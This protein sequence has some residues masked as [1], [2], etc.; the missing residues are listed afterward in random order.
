MD[1]KE[2]KPLMEKTEL[3]SLNPTEVVLQQVSYRGH[4]QAALVKYGT[5]LEVSVETGDPIRALYAY[6]DGGLKERDLR[7]KAFRWRKFNGPGLF[8]KDRFN[9]GSAKAVTITEGEEDAMAVY[10]MTGMKY[11]VVSVQSSGSA[12]KDVVADKDWVNSFE[13]I[14]IDFDNDVHGDKAAAAVASLF[15]YNKVRIVKKTKWKDANDFLQNNAIAEYQKIWFNAKPLETDNLVSSFSDLA[16]ILHAPDK[17]AIAHFPFKELEKATLGIRTG[18]T[19]LFKALEGI[20][21]TELLGAIEYYVAKTTDVPIGIIHLEEP[22][23]RSLYRFVNYEIQ[24]PVHLEGISE[25][26]TEEEK[27]NI[28]KEIAKTDNRISFYKKGKNDVN[29]DDF[30]N[31]VRFMVSSAGCKIV[32]FDH[33][34]RLATTFRLDDERKELDYISTKLSEMAEELNFALLM[35]THVNDD[36]QTRGSRNI[37]K[38][39]W[40]VIHLTRDPKAEDPQARNTTELLIEK[41]RHASTT[42]PAGAIHFNPN[43]FTLS[44]GNPINLPPTGNSPSMPF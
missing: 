21:K 44:D 43:T 1:E 35:I 19:Y 5:K 8:G 12:V 23:K 38:E 18:E 25:D 2:G 32:F 9:A 17:K 24:Q 40:T 33:I 20:G 34:T 39:A 26:I 16:E 29:S 3:K 14:Y 10:E 37:S 41:N 22:V 30:L 11:P 27:L 7:E 13:L 15:P 6:P 36:G 4:A 31:A 28:F 42:G